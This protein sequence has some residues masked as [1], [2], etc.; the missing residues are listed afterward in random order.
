M[1]HCYYSNRVSGADEDL[2]EMSTGSASGQRR[3]VAKTTLNGSCSPFALTPTVLEGRTHI[4]YSL[5]CCS[6]KAPVGCPGFG[7][8]PGFLGVGQSGFGVC[9]VA[10]GCPCP[11]EA[12]NPRLPLSDT[13]LPT[14]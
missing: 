9:V 3:R 12:P 13:G 1:P 7:S 11:A 10:A 8:L 14:A 4:Q 6:G 2:T 5:F